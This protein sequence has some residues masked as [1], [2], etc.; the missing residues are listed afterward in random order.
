MEK[1][2]IKQVFLV[3]FMLAMLANFALSIYIY[4]A[5][6]G[7]G[8]GGSCFASDNGGGSCLKVQ[9][10]SYSSLL[11]IPLAIYGVVFFLFLFVLFL[12]IFRESKKDWFGRLAR[13]YKTH[14][15]ISL[16]LLMM[17]GGVFSLWLLSLQFF[18]IKELC[19]FCLWIDG[20]TLGSA[21]VFLWMFSREIFD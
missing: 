12:G 20:I 13:K 6:N 21:I 4:A 7:L 3:I 17:W 1:F 15:R 10:S 16:V 2:K 5:E 11:G 9:L 18:I 14:T 8:P 19:K